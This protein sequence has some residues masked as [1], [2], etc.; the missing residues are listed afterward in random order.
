MSTNPGTPLPNPLPLIQINGL[1][2]VGK[3]TTAR[4]LQFLLH[5]HSPSPHQLLSAR[6]VDNHLLIDPAD[7]VLQRTEP[8]YQAL[9]RALRSVVLDPIAE[10]PATH[11]HVYIFT[12]CQSDDPLG[13]ATGVHV[14]RVG[15]ADRVARGGKLVDVTLL[16]GI[17]ETT[18]I[19]R[20][21]EEDVLGGT[22][23]LD[24]TR[25]SPEEAAVRIMQ[26][27]LDAHPELK[28]IIA[29]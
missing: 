7:A 9:R 21:T 29:E 3:L 18:V 22:L 2:G 26:H 10:N 8:G 5:S 17:R 27:V 6:L 20:F 19:H 28:T 23:E 13:A 14:E 25:L 11:G 1:P 15:A 12:D 4:A 24:V 16:K